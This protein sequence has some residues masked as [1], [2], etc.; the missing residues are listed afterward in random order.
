[1]HRFAE[2]CARKARLGYC[3]SSASARR[4][5]RV[6]SATRARLTRDQRTER[7]R[8]LPESVVTVTA[9]LCVELP[10][11]SNATTR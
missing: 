4:E 7:R 10:A 9:S 6:A 5:G 1:M 3:G 11:A 8:L 2:G